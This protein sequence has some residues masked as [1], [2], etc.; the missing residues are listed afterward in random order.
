[1][2][3]PARLLP[4]LG[5]LAACGTPAALP[6]PAATGTVV[7]QLWDPGAAQPTTIVAERIT[8]VGQRFD[9]LALTTV[10]SRVILPEFDAALT[11]PSG[12]WQAQSG[13]LSLDGPVH[14]AGTWQGHPLLGVATSARLVR[15]DATIELAGLELWNQGQRL[16]APLAVLHQDRT[17]LAPQ[18]LSSG[19]LPPELLAAFAALPDPL[20]LPH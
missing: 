17:L 20:P 5:L 15:D 16:L 1:M 11:S 19:P 9:R 6:P 12:T 8:Q 14:L 13:V 4:L 2:H 10:R 3:R 18:G 7:V